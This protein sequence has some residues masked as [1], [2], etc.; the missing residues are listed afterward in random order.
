MR[1]HVTPNVKNFL[2]YETMRCDVLLNFRH[3]TW[4]SG[5]EATQEIGNGFSSSVG[6]NS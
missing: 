4:I 2:Q 3:G 6:S 5:F 1:V